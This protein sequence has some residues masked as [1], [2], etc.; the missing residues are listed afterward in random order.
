V[1][2]Q[3]SKQGGSYGQNVQLTWNRSDEKRRRQSRPAEK[4]TQD[5]VANHEGKIPRG[6]P[7]CKLE[8]YIKR[9]FEE[10][11][12]KKFNWTHSVQDEK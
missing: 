4:C 11:R 2:I 7:G 9:A 8:D 6:T 10:I 3:R 12:P 5:L 1:R